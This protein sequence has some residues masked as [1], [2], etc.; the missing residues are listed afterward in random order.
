MRIGRNRPL[1]EA[2]FGKLHRMALWIAG[3]PDD[4]LTMAR[5]P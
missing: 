1:L 3:R 5:S 4:I 2:T